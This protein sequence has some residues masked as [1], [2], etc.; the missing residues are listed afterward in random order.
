VITWFLDEMHNMMVALGVIVAF[1]VICSHGFFESSD[2]CFM[3]T[4][5][6]MQTLVHKI[7]IR[8]AFRMQFLDK[9]LLADLIACHRLH[10]ALGDDET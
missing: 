8:N 5:C 4:L 10:H 9:S 7:S 2:E 6:G 1:F 3:V